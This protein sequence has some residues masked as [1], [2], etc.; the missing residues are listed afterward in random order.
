MIASPCVGICQ[1]D[2]SLGF[3]IGCARTRAE[4][5]TWTT[6]SREMIDRVWAELPSRRARIRVGMHRLRW[7]IDDLR[8]YVVD[9]LRSGGGTWVAGVYG[10]VAE[11]CVGDGEPVDIDAGACTITAISPR[12][13]MSLALAE[14]VRALAFGEAVIVL[15]IP[16]EHATLAT[17]FGLTSLGRDAGSVRPSGRDEQ[18]YDLGLGRIAAGFG[19]R[20]AEP[21]LRARL[22]RCAGLSWQ[23]VL[24]RIGAEI[25]QSSPTRVVRHSLG[26]IEV[27][28]PIPPPGGPSPEGPHTHFQPSDIALQA[29]LPPSLQI[30]DTYVPCAIHYPEAAA[31][32][33]CADH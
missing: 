9:T 32:G 26:R 15:A 6:A 4:I 5:A 21:A 18:L 31:T 28:T 1:I 3:C 27:F 17:R 13:A 22:D 16:R 12:G 2:E 20:T 19:V 29:D 30:A 33:T 7:T 25:V 8:S 14:H 24:S 10:A 23:D 11:F